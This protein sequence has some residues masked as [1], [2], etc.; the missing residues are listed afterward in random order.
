M[1]TYAGYWYLINMLSM[2]QHPL[3]VGIAGGS[4]SGKS[5][6]AK[7]LQIVLEFYI[8]TLLHED[9]Y[10]VD[11]STLPFAE[12]EVMNFDHPDSI[13]I[14]LLTHHVYN[15]SIGNTIKQPLYNFNTHCRR[16]KTIE[17]NPGQIVIVEGILILHFP[18]L[19][20]LMD[21]RVFVNTDERIRYQRRL[22]RDVNERGRSVISI[23]RQYEQTVLPMYREYV[24]PSSRFADMIV[25]G[26]EDNQKDIISLANRIKR[27]LS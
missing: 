16:H 22:N 21:L 20:E 19:R 15:L 10:Y 1:L 5:W 11:C 2:N 25:C 17:V 14:S 9:N 12:R 3:I 24:E 18:K 6:F 13:D 23:K 26:E 27:S 4:G 7:Q 8:C